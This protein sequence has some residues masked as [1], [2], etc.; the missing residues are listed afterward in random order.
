MVFDDSKFE[1]ANVTDRPNPTK[2]EDI[3]T[4]SELNSDTAASSEGIP[5]GEFLSVNDE[6]ANFPSAFVID[7]AGVANKATS[8]RLFK[9]FCIKI[10]Y[11][12]RN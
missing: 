1:P 3:H 7:D 4:V 9:Y 2:D 5:C 12:C 8:C 10:H 6:E 11:N